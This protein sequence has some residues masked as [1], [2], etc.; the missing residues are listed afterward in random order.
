[1][2]SNFCPNNTLKNK[3]KPNYNIHF[4]A[5][6]AAPNI[7]AL[8]P[9]SI[10]A[11]ASGCRRAFLWKRKP[12]ERNN[13]ARKIGFFLWKKAGVKTRERQKERVPVGAPQSAVTGR[14]PVQL[15]ERGF[16]FFKFELLWQAIQSV[17]AVKKFLVKWLLIA[18]G[19]FFLATGIL[20]IFLPLLP[21][22]PFLLLAA[23]CYA[24]SSEKFY[25]RLLNSKV[26]GNFIRNYRE[27]KGISK[28]AKAVTLSM[29][30]ITISFSA[31]FATQN[32]F[33]R[34]ILLLA[35]A[36]VTIHILSIK[37]KF[38]ETKNNSKKT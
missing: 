5:A 13:F 12:R 27:G 37:Q 17:V 21:T 14:S 26:P 11:N 1:M 28:K 30:W 8:A 32:F 33:A 19:T 35:A 6:I 36:S 9:L 31:V 7:Q 3:N 18:A 34:I 16:L 38:P 10:V 23:A 4:W 22:T 29:L 15:R 20:G 24:K 25:N 2:S